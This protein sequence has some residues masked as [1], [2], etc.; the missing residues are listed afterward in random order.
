MQQ[1]VKV[2]TFLSGHGETPI[3]PIHEDRIN[4]WL[5]NNP[6]EVTW[7]TQSE[8]RREGTGHHVTVCVWY[9]PNESSGS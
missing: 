1:R 7:I 8:S 5:A 2:F 6:G 9:M 4:Q 3:E